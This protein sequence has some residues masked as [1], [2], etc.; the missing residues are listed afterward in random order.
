MQARL[1]VRFKNEKGEIFFDTASR[2]LLAG[3]LILA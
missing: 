3:R 1:M 2:F